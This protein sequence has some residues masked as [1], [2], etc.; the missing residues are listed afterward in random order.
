MRAL[1]FLAPLRA[2]DPLHR[3]GRA[4]RRRARA[5]AQ[6]GAHLPRADLPQPGGPAHPQLPAQ[7]PLPRGRPSASRPTS[8]TVIPYWRGPLACATGCSPRCPPEW[9][10]AYEAGIFTEFMEQRAPGHTVLDDK[11]Y[12]KGLL[13]FKARHRRRRRRARLRARP[14]RR[15]TGARQLKAMDIA[16]DAVILFA[17][18]HAALAERAAPP[19]SPTRPARRARDDRRGL[20]P[21]ARATPRA[22]STRRSST[23]GSATWRSSPS[24]TAGTRSTPATSTSTC[25]RSTERG[26]PTARSPATRRASCWSASSSSST[27]T[28]RRPR[29]ASPPPRAAPTPTSPTSTSAACCATAPTAPTRSPTCCSTSSTRCTCCSRAPTSSS[30]ARAPTP[31]SSTPCGWSARATA[32]RRSSTPTPWSQE[33]LRQ[34]KT[35]EDARAGGCSGCVEVGA[36]GKEAY[37][38]TGYFNL[39]KVLE[40]ALHD[41]VDPRTGQPAR[42]AHRRPRQP[43]HLRRALR[44][45]RGA[46]PPLRRRQDPR[47]PAHRAACTPPQCRPRSSRCSSTTASPAGRDY[48]AGGARY[49]NTFIQF[50]GIGT[51]TDSLAA[52]RAA[53]LRGARRCPSPTCVAAL[54]ADFAGQEPLRQRLVNRMPK[55]GNDDDYGGRPH[56]AGL[57]QRFSTTSTA[58]PTPR[59]GTTAIEMLPTTCHVYFGSV[60]GA[61]P[62]GRRAG[63][64]ALRGDLP[65]AGRGPPR[66]DRRP[67]LGRQ[68][69]PRQDRRHPAQHE[70]HARPCSPATTGSSGWPHLVRAYFKMDGHHVQFNVVTRRDPAR[71]PGATR[72]RTAT[73]S[74][75]WP[76][77][78][79]TSATSP[80]ELQEEIIARTEHQEL[81]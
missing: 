49:N 70:V 51:I 59:A 81:G 18:R 72:R 7:D 77:T 65:G 56:G 10:A 33:Q 20:P 46:A 25:C 4:H 62:D 27:T 66:P 3:R 24:S 71:G 76:A 57:R 40:L 34:G 30:R 15:S 21:R 55:Y 37:I 58:G 75:A 1:A 54:D 11:I 29:W 47:Q 23:T 73:S 79:T 8:E 74:S 60:T 36:F 78:A 41:G 45:L 43:R 13:D 16:C 50:V 61:T 6:G 44:R 28:R 52:L 35:L 26:W 9:H 67:P 69:G 68:D 5:R 2:Q 80:R 53:G 63:Q 14:A 19:T 17:E 38:L 22:T 32:S 31:S 42:P 48:N 12:G 39:P 64:P